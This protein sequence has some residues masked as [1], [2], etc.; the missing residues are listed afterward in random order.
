MGREIGRTLVR[1]CERTCASSPLAPR[2]PT[3]RAM[4]SSSRRAGRPSRG[5]GAQRADSHRWDLGS[6]APLLPGDASLA[7]RFLVANLVILLVAGL[8]VGLWVGDQLERGIIDADGRRHR[9]CTSS[10]SSSRRS[11]RWPR[12]GAELTPEE[13]AVL[14]EHLA[15]SPLAD[16]SGRC[17][18]G[19]PTGVIVVQPGR[20]PHRRAASRSKATSRRRWAATIVA[21]MDDL[22]GAE[23]AWERARWSRLLEMYMPVRE[24][25]SDRIIARRRVLP[26]AAGD[27]PASRRCAADVL[28]GREHRASIA[29]AA[30]LFGIVRQGSDTI[31]RQEAAL[32]R[33]VGELPRSLD[34]NA[35]LQRAGAD[36]GR[37]NDDPQ[38]AQAAPHQRATCTTARARCSR[39]RCC[40]STGCADR[41]AGRRAPSTDELPGRDGAARRDVR[42]ALDRGR[43][44]AA[45]ARASLDCRAGP[46][47]A[48]SDHERRS[49]TNVELAMDEAVLIDALAPVE[50]RSLPR[51]PGVALQR[52]TP[53]GRCRHPRP[54]RRGRD[55]GER[56]SLEVADGGPGFDPAELETSQGLGLAGIRERAELLGGAVRRG[57]APGS[58]T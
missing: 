56:L 55:D 46:A 11:R 42:H 8:A 4:S 2:A 43:P 12:Q 22:S 37:A 58:G 45:R 31:V 30:L 18:S 3:M 19:R 23:N 41:A 25:G 40:A 15:T 24:R 44:P 29:S 6:R 28:G 16:R 57:V 39:S 21:D 53:R 48:V 1:C 10:R 26:A 17:G 47:R 33:Q 5:T 36:R 9:R 49:G 50:D 54:A 32:T 27:R 13:I 35:Q 7:R 34:Q 20:E 51:A 14:D 52:D 38:R